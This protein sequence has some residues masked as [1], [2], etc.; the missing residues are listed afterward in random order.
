VEEV[1]VNSIKKGREG[2]EMKKDRYDNHLLL[3]SVIAWAIMLLIIFGLFF[4]LTKEYGVLS[5]GL[6]LINCCMV[7]LCYGCSVA[8]CGGEPKKKGLKFLFKPRCLACRKKI[9]LN[10]EEYVSRVYPLGYYHI[11]CFRMVKV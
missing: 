8:E 3:A 6:V 11:E 7:C 5:L 4:V 10:T 2:V 9:D 1:K